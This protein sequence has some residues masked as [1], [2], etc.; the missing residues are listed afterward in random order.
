MTLTG[1]LVQQRKSLLLLLV[2]Q[3]QNFSLS[4]YYNGGNGSF[5]LNE[6]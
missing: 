1:V 6:K 3:S 5:F 4:L 2:K